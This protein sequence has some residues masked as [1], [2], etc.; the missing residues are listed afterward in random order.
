MLAGGDNIPLLASAAVAGSDLDR[1][2]VLT[3]VTGLGVDGQAAVVVGLD[4]D[5]RERTGSRIVARVR[6]SG[7]LR[8]ED[9]TSARDGNGSIVSRGGGSSGSRGRDRGSSRSRGGLGRC[10]TTV[11]DGEE[12]EIALA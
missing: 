12:L 11:A 4:R 1:D 9:T 7:G 2:E 3:E 8:V 10:G 6:L 5:A